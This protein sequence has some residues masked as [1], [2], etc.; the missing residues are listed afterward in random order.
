MTY[1]VNNF[2]SSTY[3]SVS[4]NSASTTSVFDTSLIPSNGHAMILS[5]MVANKSGTTRGINMTLQKSGSASS[6]YLLY[7]VAALSR[8][9]FEIIQG[10]KFVLRR[11]DSLKAWVDSAGTNSVD[12]TVSYVIYTPAD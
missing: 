9:F 7:D 12:I 2:Y 4:A 6:A 1:P 11:G 8:T 3:T 5:V 10:N